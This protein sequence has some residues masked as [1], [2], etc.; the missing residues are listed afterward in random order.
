MTNATEEYILE[1]NNMLNSF[2]ETLAL[3]WQEFSSL[4]ISSLLKKVGEELREMFPILKFG[5]HY[6]EEWSKLV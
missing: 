6:R 2:Q 5:G 1:L 4:E 3:S